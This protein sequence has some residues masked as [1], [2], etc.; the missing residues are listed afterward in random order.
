[1]TT[2]DFLKA[3]YQEAS[4]IIDSC[5]IVYVELVRGE[6]ITLAMGTPPVDAS[7]KL[8]YSGNTNDQ[9]Y[10][11]IKE[12]L[13]RKCF[14]QAVQYLSLSSEVFIPPVR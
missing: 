1:M 14:L 9:D 13:K 11:M 3:F 10:Q 5:K 7:V 2:E 12:C 4:E 6:H 8:T